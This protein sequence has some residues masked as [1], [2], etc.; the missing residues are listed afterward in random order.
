MVLDTRDLAEF[1]RK[2]RSGLSLRDH[3]LT[4]VVHVYATREVVP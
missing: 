4:T 2:L 3:V 1:A